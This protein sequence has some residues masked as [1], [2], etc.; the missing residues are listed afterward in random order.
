MELKSRD[1]KRRAFLA[2]TWIGF[3]SGKRGS[4]KGE[5]SDSAENDFATSIMERNEK[6]GRGLFV[7]GEQI[8]GMMNKFIGRDKSKCF[9]QT[10]KFRRRF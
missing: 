6:I 1:K 9:S 10:P 5:G 2:T 7:I 4:D 8:K 3:S